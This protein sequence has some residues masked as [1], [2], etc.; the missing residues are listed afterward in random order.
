MAEISV[1]VPIYNGEQYLEEALNSIALQS[2]KDFEV[3]LVC[4]YGTSNES[5]DIV[6]K[7]RKNDKR[8]KIITNTSKLGIS[9]SLNV[10]IRKSTG[11]YIAR[12]DADDI[13]GQ[14]RLEIQ[15]LYMDY[16]SNIG[17]CGIKHKVINSPRW[18]VDY[19]SNPEQINS[20]LLF[21]V[22][23][24][25][26]TIMM[27]S[28]VILKNNLFYD[29]SLPGVEDYDYFIR[30]S[31]VTELTN[32]NEP[33][34]FYYRRTSENAS[35]VN[36]KR[37]EK[38]RKILIKNQFYDRLKLDF[39]DKI[40]D[41]LDV[42]DGVPFY[43]EKTY[44]NILSEL[45]KNME[46][47]MQKNNEMGIYRPECLINTMEHIWFRVKYSMDI[48]SKAK[49]SDKIIDKWRAGDYYNIWMDR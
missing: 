1:V 43:N 19:H 33:N 18:I 5:L 40:I 36:K 21:F 4:E 8:F 11:K 49:L 3:I 42:V 34:L 15:K 31:K 14:K 45:Q 24:R 22:S 35:L 28:D 12:M 17:V 13:S 30:A 25:H 47:I 48:A 41:I 23:L 44:S 39:S 32:I 2:F 10:G 7:F 29:S 46:I 27:R 16:Y 6:H 37:D 9:E 38:I 26:P 20:D